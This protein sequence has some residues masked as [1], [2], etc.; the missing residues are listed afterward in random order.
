[1]MLLI[2]QKDMAR[3]SPALRAELQRLMFSDAAYIPNGADD[4]PREDSDEPSSFVE[5]GLP[6]DSWRGGVDDV[7]ETKAVIDISTE[8]AKQL[9]ANLSTKSIEI[10]KMFATEPTV[11]LDALV[12]ENCPYANFGELKRSFVGA[13]NRRLRTVTRNRM[14]VLFRKEA[15]S[16]EGGADEIAVRPLTAVALRDALQL[17]PPVTSSTDDHK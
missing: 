14:A 4:W 13:V 3:M 9:L 16:L 2:N 17:N 7:L 11:S 6:P 5:D 10:L 12:G 15:P 8:Q 1:M